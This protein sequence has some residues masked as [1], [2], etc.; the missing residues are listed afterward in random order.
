MRQTRSNKRSWNR[1]ANFRLWEKEEE[2]LLRELYPTGVPISEIGQKLN[3]THG[4]IYMKAHALGL[5]RENSGQFPKGVLSGHSLQT[6]RP[7]GAERITKD[8][9]LVR[10]VAG[11]KW[12]GVHRILWEEHHGPVPDGHLVVFRNSDKK[13]L[14]IDNLECISPAEDMRRKS[15]NLYPPEIRQLMRLHAKLRRVIKRKDE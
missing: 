5:R 11:S 13:D 8:G 4:Q 10:K 2:I 1:R 15:S 7:L 14:R 3:R 12:V 6:E 9:Y